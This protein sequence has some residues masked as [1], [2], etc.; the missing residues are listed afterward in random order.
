MAT[1]LREG[2]PNI[3]HPRYVNEVLVSWKIL[4]TSLRNPEPLPG[5]IEGKCNNYINAWFARLWESRTYFQHCCYQQMQKW[6]QKRESRLVEIPSR[7]FIRVRRRNYTKV[8][9]RWKSTWDS[10]FPRI[11]QRSRYLRVRFIHIVLWQYDISSGLHKGVWKS[12]T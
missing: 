1:P 7:L 3:K 6:Q 12:T 4:K 5:N 8:R 2:S 9:L 10:S 11:L